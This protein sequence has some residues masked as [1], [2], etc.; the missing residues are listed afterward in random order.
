M[1]GESTP[2][3]KMG[4]TLCAVL[5]GFAVCSWNVRGL[6][7]PNTAV[8]DKIQSERLLKRE[9]LGNDCERYGMDVVGLQETKCTNQED[10]LLHNNFRLLIFDQKEQCHVGIG[11][12]IGPK[13][14]PFVTTFK[15]IS[16]RVTFIDICLPLKGG[17]NKISE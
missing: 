17:G 2:G 3:I 6:G 16:D 13:L 7:S 15:H 8:N 11:F 12:V 4:F 14:Q 1:A 9:S 5:F 10:I